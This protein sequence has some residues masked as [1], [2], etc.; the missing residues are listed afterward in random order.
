M[1][2]ITLCVSEDYIMKNNCYR[3]KAIG[4]SNYQ[5]YSDF[6][7]DCNENEF[8]NFINYER[9]GDNEDECNKERRNSRRV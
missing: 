6:Y 3:K 7:H 4:N 8:C 1:S 9:N 5:S 2:D